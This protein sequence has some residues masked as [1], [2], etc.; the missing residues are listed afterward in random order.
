MLGQISEIAFK[1]PMTPHT[2][3]T[4]SQFQA[5]VSRIAGGIGQWESDVSDSEIEKLIEGIETRRARRTSKRIPLDLAKEQGDDL[6][7]LKAAVAH[8]EFRKLIESRL[9]FGYSVA[10]DLMKIARQ[11]GNVG[12]RNARGSLSVRQAL[13][14]IERSKTLDATPDVPK[15]ARAKLAAISTKLAW[16][17]PISVDRR[18]LPDR[19]G[20]RR[21]PLGR[22]DP[23]RSAV[24]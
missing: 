11:L 14:L 3:S 8:G 17:R 19:I 18:R 6:I 24:R 23:R 10:S 1:K 12:R 5:S 7:A 9:P 4:R 22:F 21:G 20:P 2:R 15:R 13:S 16:I